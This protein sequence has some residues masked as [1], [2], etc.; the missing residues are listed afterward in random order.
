MPG[1]NCRHFIARPDVS[2]L[3][4]RSAGGFARPLTVARRIRLISS[5]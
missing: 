1:K 3:N 5:H 4:Y 2:Q